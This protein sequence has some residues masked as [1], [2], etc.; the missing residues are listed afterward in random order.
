MLIGFLTMIHTSSNF[1]S[2]AHSIRKQVGASI[3]QIFTTSLRVQSKKDDTFK[4]STTTTTT[5]HMWRCASKQTA[6]L[7]NV[8]KERAFKE[9]FNL[10]GF[11]SLLYLP[12]TVIFVACKHRYFNRPKLWT[13]ILSM[14]MCLLMIFLKPLGTKQTNISRTFKFGYSCS[15]L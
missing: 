14:E 12:I 7:F 9:S 3:S 15:W 4:T 1:T 13:R 8:F 11:I 5:C 6:L 10:W 2:E